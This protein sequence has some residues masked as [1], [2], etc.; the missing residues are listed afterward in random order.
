MK[1]SCND[2]I[3]KLNSDDVIVLVDGNK[4]IPDFNY[5]QEYIVKGDYK[6]ASIAA[7]SILAKVSRDR[8]M[9]ELD[10]EFPMYN[11]AKNKGYLTK[12]HLEAVDK[13]G[14]TVYHRKKFFVKHSQKTSQLTLF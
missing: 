9:L 8:Y 11:W 12:E 1:K 14:L 3:L 6:S 7:A 4:K 10:R 2:V 13:F 5:C